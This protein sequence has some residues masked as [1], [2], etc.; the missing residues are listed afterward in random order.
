MLLNLMSEKGIDAYRVASVLGYCLLPMVGMSAVSVMIALE[1]VSSSVSF[2][3]STNN[4]C[5]WHVWLLPVND[6][7]LVVYLCSVRDI[8]RCPSNV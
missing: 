5:Q 6:C 2:G 8:R 1:Y 4:S 3:F 7:H